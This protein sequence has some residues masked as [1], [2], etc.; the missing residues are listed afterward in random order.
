VNDRQL[1]ATILG[2]ESPWRV[3]DVRLD[4]AKGDVFVRV[5]TSEA[6]CPE[7]NE[8]RPR[9]DSRHRRWR[10]L[11]T[12]QYRTVIESDVPRVSCPEH[13]VKQVRV[14]WAEPGS[15]N[16]LLFEALLIYWLQEATPNAVARRFG[17]SWS[18][19]NDIMKRAVARGLARREAVKPEQICVDET[20]FQKRHEYVTVVTDMDSGDVLHVADDRKATSLESFYKTLPE[21]V[22]AAIRTVAMDM[23]G[24]FIKATR[25]HIPDA[26]E[27]IAFDRFHVAMSLGDAVSKVR[28]EE[29]KALRANGDDRLVGTRYLWLMNPDNM[30]EEAWNDRFS[31]L[32]ASNL[33]TAR[34]WAIKEEAAGLWHYKSHGW[35]LKAWTRWLG[36]ASRCRLQPIIKVAGTIRRHLWGIL[37]AVVSGATNATAEG[38]NAGIQRLKKRACGYRSR[39]AFRTAIYF[40]FGG[41]DL[42]PDG[43][44]AH[45]V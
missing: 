43:V 3:T 11:D 45:T 26:D 42:L 34:A 38:I 13:G 19:V 33:R 14:P 37:N 31:Q 15:K 10:H 4:L 27:K 8:K 16:T 12:C 35:A 6:R 21:D 32:R 2:I 1:Y 23:S 30:S 20:S 40:H 28:R 24:P 22:R 17:M 36:W 7:C 9:H 5:E 44:E 18:T 29:N 25:E 39:E 41:L